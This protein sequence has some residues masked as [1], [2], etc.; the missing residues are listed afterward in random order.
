L[1]IARN[2]AR[3]H[4]GELRLRNHPQGGL[5]AVLELPR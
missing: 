1:S 4:G 3:A 2:I 5:E